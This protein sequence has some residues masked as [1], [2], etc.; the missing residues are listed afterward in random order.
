MKFGLSSSEFEYL[1]ETVVIPFKKIGLTVFC[2]GS[3]ARGTHSRYSDLDLMIEGEKSEQ[4]EQLRA[5]TAERLSESHFPYKV[6]LVF[7]ED[8]VATYLEGYLTDR[9]PLE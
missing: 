7:R 3:R 8:Y 9:K 5:Q 6:D 2:F 1:R 4:A